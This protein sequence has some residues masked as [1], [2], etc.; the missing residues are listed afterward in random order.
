MAAQGL[1]ADM[2]TIGRLG[3]FVALGTAPHLSCIPDALFSPPSNNDGHRRHRH[4]RIDVVSEYWGHPVRIEPIIEYSFEY[5]YARPAVVWL[6]SKAAFYKIHSVAPAYQSH[7]EQVVEAANLA[8]STINILL[9]A[10]LSRG[11]PAILLE[12]AQLARRPP[13]ELVQLLTKHREF[14]FRQIKLQA[15]IRL[16]RSSLT[17]TLST[18][19]AWQSFLDQHPNRPPL[20]DNPPSSVSSNLSP[21][22]TVVVPSP[23]GASGSA[24]KPVVSVAG[25]TPHRGRRTRGYAADLNSLAIRLALPS[26]LDAQFACPFCGLYIFRHDAP[27]LVPKLADHVRAVHLGGPRPG[28]IQFCQ[29]SIDAE[30]ARTTPWPS[31]QLLPSALRPESLLCIPVH[32]ALLPAA[33]FCKWDGETVG[34]L[35]DPVAPGGN[36]P[37]N[38]EPSQRAVHPLHHDG[39]EG[40]VEKLGVLP[41]GPLLAPIGSGQLEPCPVEALQ[42]SEQS[43]SEVPKARPVSQTRQEPALSGPSIMGPTWS[44]RDHHREHAPD[45]KKMKLKETT[46][47]GEKLAEDVLPPMGTKFHHPIGVGKRKMDAAAPPAHSVASPAVAKHTAATLALLPTAIG[48]GSVG[49]V[50]M[51]DIRVS[52]ESAAPSG[53]GGASSIESFRPDAA[54]QRPLHDGTVQKGGRST[55]PGF[56]AAP[57]AAI[58]GGGAK[59]S[60]MK[61]N[62]ETNQQLCLPYLLG[63]PESTT[64]PSRFS[65]ADGGDLWAESRQRQQLAR[66]PLGRANGTQPF[67]CIDLTVERSLS[68]LPAGDRPRPEIQGASPKAWEIAMSL[69]HRL[70]LPTP[71]SRKDP[72]APSGSSPS[73][74][75][76]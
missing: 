3:P 53:D 70:L 33:I 24:A 47:K 26:P 60:K 29:Q 10:P 12:I 64:M 4:R 68:A 8:G 6:R 74:Q 11:I 27:S 5:P 56:N 40:A 45:P 61:P 38:D 46:I 17:K 42:H 35:S 25:H 16:S 18:S 30:S 76:R 31:K 66:A 39:S 41:S 59:A 13:S 34:G 57:M 14:V 43:C 44:N 75:Q 20:L 55:S 73:P 65:Q 9:N 28:P 50:P 58:N 49:A 21:P 62:D 15:N 52:L 32:P 7:W 63:S 69:G 2:T 67:H 54:L 23:S 19:H 72:R 36:A 51:K 1:I 71:V 22:P 48:G 37:V